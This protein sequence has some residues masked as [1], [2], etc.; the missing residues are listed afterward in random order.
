MID[1]EPDRLTRLI[2]EAIYIRKEGPQSMNRD[3]VSYQ[4]SH[5]YDRFPGKSSSS[6]RRAKSQ[7]N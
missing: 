1:T 2:K 5:A 7:K 6:S 3:E 4:L